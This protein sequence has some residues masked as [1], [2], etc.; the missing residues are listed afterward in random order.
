MFGMH[1]D[2]I[3]NAWCLVDHGTIGNIHSWTLID[4]AALGLVVRKK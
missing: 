4:H 2:S 1:L 3:G